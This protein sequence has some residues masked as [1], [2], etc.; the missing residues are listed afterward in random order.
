MNN[1]ALASQIDWKVRAIGDYGIGVSARLRVDGK[2]YSVLS[3]YSGDLMQDLTILGFESF[4][5]SILEIQ[6]RLLEQVYG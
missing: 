6:S 4:A 5:N 3:E 1:E 2:A